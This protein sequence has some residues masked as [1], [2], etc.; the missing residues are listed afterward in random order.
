MDK[1]TMGG[2]EGTMWGEGGVIEREAGKQA[3]R[4]AD[5]DTGTLGGTEKDADRQICRRT[6]IEANRQ[7]GIQIDKQK[8]DAQAE[9]QKKKEKNLKHT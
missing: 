8:T 9:R 4:Q 6:E 3:H 1:E 5:R 2:K 7:T